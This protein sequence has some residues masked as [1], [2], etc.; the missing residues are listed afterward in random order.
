[1][2]INIIYMITEYIIKV[3]PL[4][5]RNL[6]KIISPLLEFFRISE[7]SELQQHDFL[8]AGCHSCKSVSKVSK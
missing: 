1:M 3:I 4:Y 2:V 5:L 6:F 8:Q 7:F